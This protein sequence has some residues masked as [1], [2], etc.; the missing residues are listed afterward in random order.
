[1]AQNE[2]TNIPA[3]PAAK[4]PL[5]RWV[6]RQTSKLSALSD[7]ITNNNYFKGSTY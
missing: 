2:K 6:I 5:W 3:G 1:M 4:W 7:I